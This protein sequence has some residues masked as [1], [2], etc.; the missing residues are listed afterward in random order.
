MDDL[1]D[2][3]DDLR[4][5]KQDA[6]PDEN[7]RIHAMERLEVGYDLAEVVEEYAILRRCITSLLYSEHTPALR[8]G[9]LPRLHEAIDLA[10]SSSVVRYTEARER[11]LRALDRISQTALA[12]PDVESLLPNT[13]YA[14]L[15]TTA[16]VDSV[17]LL[18]REED[19]LRV[20]AAVGYPGEGPV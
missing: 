11:T 17:A 5:G 16:A 1:A 12:H 14:F 18:L 13:L 15:E 10:I 8:S 2:Y 7:P 3:V 20:R 9:E 19:G 4:H 6:P